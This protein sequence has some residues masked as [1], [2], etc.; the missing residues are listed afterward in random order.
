M[1]VSCTVSQEGSDVGYNPVLSVNSVTSQDWHGLKHLNFIWGVTSKCKT[2][3]NR[4]SNLGHSFAT[5]TI[6]KG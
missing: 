1:S 6:E 3:A 5:E 2:L 4:N